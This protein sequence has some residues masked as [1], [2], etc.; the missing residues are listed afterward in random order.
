MEKFVVNDIVTWTSSAGGI[1]K[2]KV[3]PVVEVIQ[4]GSVPYPR[5]GLRADRLGAARNH[6]SYVVKV[7]SLFYWPR[8]NSLT[9]LQTQINVSM[10][11][12]VQK[13]K[14]TEIK[15]KSKSL[16]NELYNTAATKQ[17]R[18]L[19]NVIGFC[20]DMSGSMSDLT[21]TAV[22]DFNAQ[23]ETIRQAAK[24]TNQDTY[25]A[26]SYFGVNGDAA[27]FTRT[28]YSNM[29]K[30]A[31]PITSI[32]VVENMKNAE[33]IAY[34]RTP[35]RDSVM[36][37]IDEFEKFQFNPATDDVSFLIMT[38]TDGDENDSQTRSSEFLTRLNLKQNLGNWSFAFRVPRGAKNS[39]VRSEGVLPGNVIEWETTVRGFE[40]STIV[41][42]A[43]TS[44]FYS[45]RASGQTATRSFYANVQADDAT[46]K[47]TLADLTPRVRILPVV[48]DV[49]IKSFVEFHGENYKKGYGYY[50]LTK[51]EE[52]Q[53]YKEVLVQD[54]IDG[55]IY[56]GAD[57]RNLLGIPHTGSIRLR[58]GNTGHYDV[59]VQSTS[60][61]RKLINGTRMIYRTI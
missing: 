23:L 44:G 6:E 40:Q 49:E 34:G 50:Q 26:V 10:T 29:L 33:Y 45:A 39:F 56:G 24:D 55:K 28:K 36:S 15:Q 3:G 30:L 60:V 48:Q 11:A 57:S 42:S 8:V 7:G 2:N 53:D 54:K 4:A 22:K 17:E 5:S 31:R 47:K 51:P 12:P 38:L 16:I 1:S 37:I 20:L 61:N 9:G 46:I 21:S 32:S 59:F 27:S 13:P 19:V 35:L 25:I 43:A 41:A 52:V 18:K 58:P 14:G